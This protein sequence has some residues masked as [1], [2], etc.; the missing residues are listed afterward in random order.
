MK[1]KRRNRSDPATDQIARD[2][3]IPSL[4]LDADLGA[5]CEQ[6]GLQPNGQPLPA[7]EAAK[8][9]QEQTIADER[10]EAET[11]RYRVPFHKLPFARDI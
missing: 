7:M 2:R 4:D 9:A 8:R 1:R 5:W 11:P 3:A 10:R 6:M